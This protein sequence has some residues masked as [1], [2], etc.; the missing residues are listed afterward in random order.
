LC[1]AVL[2][3]R[4]HLGPSRPNQGGESRGS[5]YSPESPSCSA[6]P[7]FAPALSHE[8][9]I[10]GTRTEKAREMT[11]VSMPICCHARWYVR[12]SETHWTSLLY[13]NTARVLAAGFEQAHSLEDVKSHTVLHI[14]SRRIYMYIPSTSLF[15]STFF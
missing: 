9:L 15:T 10:L 8:L 1:G 12:M 11:Q 13:S 2:A 7:A 3:L 4:V 14:L 5:L 6:L